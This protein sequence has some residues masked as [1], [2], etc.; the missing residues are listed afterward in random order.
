MKHPILFYCIHA[1]FYKASFL[2]IES[3]IKPRPGLA[4][5]QFLWFCQGCI[6]FAVFMFVRWVSDDGVED[7]T[8]LKIKSI[9]LILPGLHTFCCIHACIKAS[10]PLMESTIKS[11]WVWILSH[12][13]H[14][15]CPQ[16]KIKNVPKKKCWKCPQI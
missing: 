7:E 5:T 9:L 15:I 6:L 12:G 1:Y 8:W 10:L 11:G 16:K 3:T 13:R 4:V 2:L 14:L